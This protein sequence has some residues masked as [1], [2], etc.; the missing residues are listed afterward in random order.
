MKTYNE[1]YHAEIKPDLLFDTNRVFGSSYTPWV[2]AYLMFEKTYFLQNAP[3]RM[4]KICAEDI[5]NY[6]SIHQATVYDC[7]EQLE[8]AGLVEKRGVN[9]KLLSESNYISTNSAKL[10]GNF[11]FVRVFPNYLNRQLSDI[12]EFIPQ[13]KNN[14]GFLAKV[15]NVYYYLITCNRHCSLTKEPVVESNKTQSSLSREL[16]YDHRT[17]KSVL[18]ILESTGYIKYNDTGKILTINKDLYV[19]DSNYTI[20]T[21]LPEQAPVVK[22]ETTK[23]EVRTVPK[24]FIGFT[25]S[26]DGKKISLIY[27]NKDLNERT[28]FV[29]CEGDG[30]PYTREDY[31]KYTDLMEN[32]KRSV[33]YDPESFWQYTEQRK[34]FLKKIKNAA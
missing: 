5:S 2:Y 8:N 28:A 1:K 22:T 4:Y 20:H 24:D 16:K 11:K 14:R 34:A 25:K 31:E 10:W 15:L 18:G 12:K 3:N 30:T 29:W 13:D 26:Q 27:F 19:E 21:Y 9:Y 33:Y 7:I 32:G 17:I 6:F 23:T